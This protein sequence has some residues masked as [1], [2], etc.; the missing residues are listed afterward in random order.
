MCNRFV[1]EAY[2]KSDFL[3]VFGATETFVLVFDWNNDPDFEQYLRSGHDIY[4]ESATS[5][6][7]IRVT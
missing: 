4:I 3:A 2:E 5:S 7:G 1:N 6:S